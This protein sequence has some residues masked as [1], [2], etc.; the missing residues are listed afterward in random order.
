MPPSDG[1]K[2]CYAV[3][4]AKRSTASELQHR[5]TLLQFSV[6]APGAARSWLLLCVAIV[7][8]VR[9]T[10]SAACT[11]ERHH[12]RG[13]SMRQ[14]TVPP[15][16]SPRLN[17]KTLPAAACCPCILWPDATLRQPRTELLRLT[18]VLKGRRLPV[19]PS[20]GC[21]ALCRECIYFAEGTLWSR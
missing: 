1:T 18:A 16:E 11:K 17:A 20:S 21:K 12:A 5:S 10:F 8:L 15:K 19:A 2:D 6:D 9:W 13:F 7:M 4:L 3:S 14:E